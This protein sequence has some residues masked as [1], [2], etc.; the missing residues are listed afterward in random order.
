MIGTSGFGSFLEDSMP[1]IT[2]KAEELSIAMGFLGE[3]IQGAT[4]ALVNLFQSFDWPDLIT[5]YVINAGI[6]SEADIR[7][8]YYADGRW[9]VR[10]WNHRRI[11][12]MLP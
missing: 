3:A 8:V 6:A 2:A 12:V 10:L 4:Q 9:W 5:R 11:P 1:K 7:E